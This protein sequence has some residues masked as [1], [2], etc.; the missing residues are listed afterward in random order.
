MIL[1]IV[2]VVVGGGGWLVN[3]SFTGGSADASHL[4]TET[5]KKG[6]FRIVVSERGQLDSLK[7]ATITSGVEGTT[8]I[9][10]IVP[11]GTQV[12]AGQLVCELDSS[13][14]VDKQKEQQIKLTQA[15][16]DLEKA[17]KN[18]QIQEEQNASD[19]AAANLLFQL[20]ELDLN[21]FEKGD[22]SKLLNE[23]DGELQL[24]EEELIRAKDTY[25]F[26][27]RIA[28]KGYKTQQELE[29]NRIAVKKAEIN[30]NKAE[31]ALRVLRDY[32]FVRTH[33]ELK[34]KVEEAKREQNRVKLQGDASLDQFNA[35]LQARELA[36][37]VETEK[38]TKLSEQIAACKLYAPQPGEVVYP[39]QR[40]RRNEGQAIEE[41][42]SVRQLQEILKLP[43]L[44]QMKV[45]A[46]IHESRIG[47]VS[48]GMPVIVHVDA[49]GDEIYRGIVDFISSVP[50]SPDYRTPDLRQYA[51]VVRLTESPERVSKLK[52]GLTANIEI[53]A[54]QRENVLQVPV[55]AV[56]SV[57]PKRYAYVVANGAAARREVEIGQSSTKSIEITQ[58]LSEREQVVMN[59]RTAF[60]DELADLAL[61]LGVS[62]PIDVP[63]PAA[64][65]GEATESGDPSKAANPAAPAAPAKV[66][67][68]ESGPGRQSREEGRG[69][70][71]AKGEGR[72][73]E[74]RGEGRRERRP[75]DPS[76]MIKEGDKNG[77]GKLSK[78]ETNERMQ[79][80]FDRLDA[81]KDGFLDKG[82]LSKMGAM[83]RPGGE[84]GAAGGAPQ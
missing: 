16:A 60:S 20:A 14:L 43:D 67:A 58:G 31:E 79:P 63:V 32:E 50:L 70:E 19:I 66:D 49:A 18:V 52:P 7:S 62:N 45:E 61:Q 80:F 64:V 6:P 46:K 11:E 69:G 51:A 36:H 13:T 9:I 84:G 78:D 76:A 82:E 55:Q 73:G 10:F 71:G 27:K 26:S 25:E 35:E 28:K 34:E 3:L 23:K 12:H 83:R 21:K 8:T 44:S 29:A 37:L 38:A 30:R 47:L 74:G 41:G 72:K 53:V 2:L 15:T 59:P 77:D 56:V 40:S 1:A 22:K 48:K 68:A 5:V 39:S 17:R 42:A 75:R 81:N 24:A 54:E 57:G 4:V 65:D 33:A